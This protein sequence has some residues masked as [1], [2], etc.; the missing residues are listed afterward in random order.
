MRVLLIT[1]SPPSPAARTAV[2]LVSW[3]QLAAV[4]QHHDVTLL[5]TA[6]PDAAEW[7][8]VEQLRDSGLDVRALTRVDSGARDRVARWARNARRWLTTG[9][10]MYTLWYYEP[11]L[12]RILNTLLARERFDIIHVNDAAMA[13]YKLAT[14][15]PKLLVEN[16]VRTPR[17]VSIHKLLRGNLYRGLLDEADWHRWRTYQRRTWRNFD[18]IN[19]FTTHDARIARQI[20][21][22]IASRVSVNPFGISTTAAADPAREVPGSVLFVGN[23]THA[24]NV[25]AAHWLAREVMPLLRARYAD[26]RLHICGCDPRGALRAI[27]C[28]DIEVHGWVESLEAIIERAAVVVAPVRIG[29]GQRMKVL[30]AMA[31]GKAVVTTPRGADGLLGADAAEP[32]VACGTS[33]VEIADLTAQL[34][35]DGERRHA[36]GAR[37]RELVMEYHDVR[38]YGKRIDAAYASLVERSHVLQPVGA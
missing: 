20:A 2:P 22:D 19:V 9:R 14:G 33:A 29:G 13:G 23:F 32:P 38:A 24:P 34:L 25:D 28:D 17:P 21:P 27:A 7:D 30:Q 36:L 8:A 12:Q 31:M 10:P 16:E 26:V 35:R 6:G 1:P 18:H 4:R 15:A 37:A 5:T 3:A 11:E